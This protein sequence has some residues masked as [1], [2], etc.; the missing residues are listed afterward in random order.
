MSE[1]SPTPPIVDPSPAAPP[2]MLGSTE[3]VFPPAEASPPEVLELKPNRAEDATAGPHPQISATGY[4]HMSKP[5]GS[6]FLCPA[7][8][9]EHYEAKGFVKGAEEDVPDLD[10]YWAQAATPKPAT[11]TRST[12]KSSS[13]A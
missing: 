1:T 4:V 7:S 3:Y 12:S 10:A 2:I 11:S 9:V 6:D 5:D 13:S 8:N